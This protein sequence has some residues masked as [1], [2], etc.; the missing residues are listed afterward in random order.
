M[1]VAVAE[2]VGCPGLPLVALLPQWVHDRSWSPAVPSLQTSRRDPG[3]TSS[4]DRDLP[5]S[6]TPGTEAS[7]EDPPELEDPAELEEPAGL[8]VARAGTESA[9]VVVPAAG[10]AA[11]DDA[12]GDVAGA[13]AGDV[14]WAEAGPEADEPECW[15]VH[16][17]MSTPATARAAPVSNAGE[18]QS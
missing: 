18:R 6:I 2:G 7:A 3:R 11:G 14:A 12:A 17:T 8:G 4:W 15:G 13:D 5:Q 10:D 1:A 9:G 16:P